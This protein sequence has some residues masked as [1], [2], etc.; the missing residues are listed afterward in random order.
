MKPRMK[1]V[2]AAACLCAFTLSAAVTGFA[3]DDLP[4]SAVKIQLN[5]EEADG[6]DGFREMFWVCDG[7]TYLPLRL[8]FPWDD[9][10]PQYIV[11]I[12]YSGTNGNVRI[13]IYR[14]KEDGSLQAEKKV[15]VLRWDGEPN[16]DGAVQ[17]RMELYR[18]DSNSDFGKENASDIQNTDITRKPLANPLYFKDVDQSGGQRV[19]ISLADL[20]TLVQFL[21]GDSNYVVNL[22]A[23]NK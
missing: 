5:T 4:K 2:L 18:Y 19:F 7:T 17:G 10:S 21:I 3:A 12:N 23:A 14:K 16:A 20:E 6:A 1:K 9:N 8:A 13:K 11:R 22:I 15:V